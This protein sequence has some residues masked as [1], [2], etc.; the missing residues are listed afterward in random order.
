MCFFSEE[1]STQ[2]S[3]QS[4]VCALV[5][6]VIETDVKPEL[7]VMFVDLSF[8]GHSVGEPLPDLRLRQTLTHRRSALE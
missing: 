2:S 1:Y 3:N 6:V 7:D 8:A 4:R 5:S